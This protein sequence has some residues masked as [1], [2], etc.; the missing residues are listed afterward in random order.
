MYG[1]ISL[2]GFFVAAGTLDLDDP[3]SFI[4]NSNATVVAVR[5]GYK[6]LREM[7]ELGFFFKADN[8]K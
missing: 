4:Y 6:Q 1:V 7:K 5:A 2:I 8:H 3:N